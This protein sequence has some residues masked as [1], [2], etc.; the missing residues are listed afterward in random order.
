MKQF[1]TILALTGLMIACTP[2]QSPKVPLKSGPAE[3]I[4]IIDDNENHTIVWT[5]EK[6]SIEGYLHWVRE[7]GSIL[8]LLGTSS[9]NGFQFATI[10]VTVHDD[11][12][13]VAVTNAKN[14]PSHTTLI[15]KDKVVQILFKEP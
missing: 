10:H 4:V 7:D 5:T 1:I 15:Q 8:N 9:M 12:V 11:W 2:S 3:A 14:G 6:S 13:E